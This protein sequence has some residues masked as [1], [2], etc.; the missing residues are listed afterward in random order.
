M[1][2]SIKN[3]DVERLARAVAAESG[4]S[5]TDA[6]RHALEERLERIRGSRMAPTRVESIL[7][8]ARRCQALPDLDERSPE[9]I[10]GYGDDGTFE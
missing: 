4:E 1:P 6:V 3:E 5:L 8:I 7:E 9:E 10:L 2:I